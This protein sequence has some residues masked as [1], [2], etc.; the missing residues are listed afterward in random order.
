MLSPHSIRAC[1]VLLLLGLLPFTVGCGPNLRARATVKGKVTFANQPV[2]AGSV[3]FYGR[4]NLLGSATIDKDGNYVMKDAPLGEVK[5]TVTVP[6]LPPGGIERMKMGPA[7]EGKSVDPSGSGKAIAIMGTMPDRYVPVSEK[8]AKV[9]TSG[10]TY[11]VKKGE[12]TH[13]IIM[14]P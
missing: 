4:D 7:K 13:D 11:T 3:T 10:L 2:T 6:T 14:T 5:I 8:Y 9:A 12:Q 1:G